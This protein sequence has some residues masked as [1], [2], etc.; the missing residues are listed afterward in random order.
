MQI[1][2]LAVGEKPPS[3]V[4]SGVKEYTSR[5][6]QECSVNLVTVPTQ[7]RTKNTS[8][9][10]N[11]EHEQKLLL[12][13]SPKNSYRIVLDEKGKSWTTKMLASEMKDWL[14]F[15]P[16]VT[17]YIGGPDGFSKQF[18]SQA[19]HIW[20]LSTL[21]MPHMLVRLVL[22]EQIYRAWTITQNHPYHR[23]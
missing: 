21:T 6:P 22:V 10:Q 9:V 20:S 14:Q 23:K 11:Q 15:K 16:V 8:I 18:F 12:K 1:F 4:E 2:I 13:A 17:F 19:D 5:M 3:W 7:K